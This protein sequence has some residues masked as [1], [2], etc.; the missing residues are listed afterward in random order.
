MLRKGFMLV[1]ALLLCSIVLLLGMGFLGSRVGQYNST[2]Q[3]SL[4]A[5]A[6]W[7]A[8]A[9]LEDARAK[10]QRDIHFPPHPS[11][12][13][14]TYSYSEDLHDLSTPP[15]YVGT[16]DVQL[17]SSHDLPNLRVLVITSRG[18]V[19]APGQGPTA[20]PLACHSYRA[21][22]DVTP[23][24]YDQVRYYPLLRFDD[25]GAL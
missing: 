13:Q 24:S 1:T 16:Y 4:A 20:P 9:G 23:S 21:C 8:R 14:T 15:Q 3:A 5:R 7:V 11:Q 18:Q 12:L 19:R 22:I 10:L 25:L 2:M 17:D 6:R